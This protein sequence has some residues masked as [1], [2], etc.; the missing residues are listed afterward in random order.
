MET[1]EFLVTTERYRERL[2]VA[3]KYEPEGE[4]FCNKQKAKSRRQKTV[5]RFLL[6]WKVSYL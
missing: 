5:K 3:R 4:K 1:K 6:H 2:K